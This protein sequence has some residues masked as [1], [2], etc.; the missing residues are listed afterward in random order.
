MFLRAERRVIAPEKGEG[1]VLFY[2]LTSKARAAGKVYGEAAREFTSHLKDLLFFD[3][4]KRG[5][6][7][8]YVELWLNDDIRSS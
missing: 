1:A 6:A 4:N 3:A 5:K 8:D 7:Y 2:A